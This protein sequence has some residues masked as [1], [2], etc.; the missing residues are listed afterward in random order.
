MSQQIAILH[1]IEMRGRGP[2]TKMNRDAMLE[3]APKKTYEDGR[4]KQC[5]K[6]DCDIDKI[7]QRFEQT[8][9]ISH[10]EKFQGV[11][12]DFSDFDF[13]EQQNKL[14]RGGEIFDALPAELRREFGQSAEAFFRYVNDPANAKDLRK[15]L[16]A[17][18]KPGRQLNKT[19]P[20]DADL[21]ARIAALEKPEGD[22]NPKPE[23]PAEPAPTAE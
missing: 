16:P 8:G 21:E 6:D 10:L 4:T 22:P 19:S 5:F 12:A 13:Q 18:A 20:P 1:S 2:K 7:M 23:K 9:T 11:Y 3:L 15:K 17:L 14:A